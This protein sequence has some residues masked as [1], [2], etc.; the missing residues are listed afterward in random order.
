MSERSEYTLPWGQALRLLLRHPARRPILDT[1]HP[2]HQAARRICAA[3]GDYEE[4]V[5]WYRE[6]LAPCEDSWR[7]WEARA[8]RG[9][10]EIANALGDSRQ[11]RQYFHAAL[12]TAVQSQEISVTLDILVGLARLMAQAGENERS[13]ELLAFVRQH[14]AS[15][16]QTQGRAERPLAQLTSQLPPEALA[17]AQERDKE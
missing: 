7:S 13:A 12:E 5:Q 8:L 9:L 6:S 14:H 3:L 11:S 15:S 17:T 4:A 16:Q 10:G 2:E 1:A